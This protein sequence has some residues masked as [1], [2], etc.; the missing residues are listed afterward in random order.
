MK[1]TFFMLSGLE[2]GR[3]TE[4]VLFNLLKYKPLEIDADV[5]VPMRNNGIRVSE[6]LIKG[7]LSNAKLIRINVDINNED[8]S[9][10]IIFTKLLLK[11]IVKDLRKYK[12]TEILQKIRDTDIVYLF[13]NPY[14]IFFYEMDIPI[15]GSNHTDGL[16]VFKKHKSLIQNKY[17]QHIHKLYYKNINGLHVFP[18]NADIL[19]SHKALKY[20]IILPNGIDTSMFYP[21]Y[22]VKNERLRLFFVAS[23]EYGKGLDILLPLIDK[24]KNNNNVEFHIAGSGSLVNEIKKRNN[25]IYHGVVDNNELSKLYRE[26][27]V[28][29][30]PSHSDTY[31]LVTLEALSSGLY[32]LCSDYLRQ[33]FDDFEDK[34]LEYLA[35]EIDVWYNKISE[36]INNREMIKHDKN[37]EYDYIKNNYSWEIISKKFYEYLI[38]F[39]N[40]NKE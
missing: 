25:I 3:G 19:Q 30:Y 29:I 20:N 6:S 27:D 5:I 39:Y 23:L 38:K 7:K 1:I 2:T 18:N 37:N 16:E 13:Y 33:I 21:D 28:F 17:Y 32:V 11:P 26:S 9:F 40:G 12:N 35:L 8:S 4:N 14:S 22:N 15:I 36:I 34:Y 31:S 24:Y 10:K